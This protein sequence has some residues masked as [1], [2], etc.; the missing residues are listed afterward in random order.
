MLTGD[1]VVIDNKIFLAYDKS[2][3]L[4]SSISGPFL[5]PVKF[6]LEKFPVDVY[7]L[8]CGATYF[9]KTRMSQSIMDYVTSKPSFK[10]RINLHKIINQLYR[11]VFHVDL[12]PHRSMNITI[13]NILKSDQIER[14][15]IDA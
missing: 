8:K 12:L 1:I 14:I 3:I 13:L 2:L 9:M 15:P 11:Q 4:G 5:M 10:E 7:R 6:Y